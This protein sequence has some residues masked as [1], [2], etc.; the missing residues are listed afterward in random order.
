M[1]AS[2]GLSEGARVGPVLRGQRFENSQRPCAGSQ[3]GALK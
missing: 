2:W 1:R 3:L